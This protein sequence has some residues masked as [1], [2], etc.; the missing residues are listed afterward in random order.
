[1]TSQ[2]R[3]CRLAALTQTLADQRQHGW[4]GLLQEIADLELTLLSRF[5][6]LDVIAEIG[7][8]SL[9]GLALPVNTDLCLP[10]AVALLILAVVNLSA[11][12]GDPDLWIRQMKL[13]ETLS[14]QLERPSGE[15][16]EPCLSRSGRRRRQLLPQSLQILVIRLFKTAVEIKQQQTGTERAEAGGRG[17]EL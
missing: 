1:M 3:P 4:T 6:K 11:G 10:E 17:E 7:K 12:L 8:S 9:N 2:L 14:G 15:D 13:C 5:L 16:S